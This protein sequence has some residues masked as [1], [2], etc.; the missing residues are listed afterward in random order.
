V[1]KIIAGA[2]A[3]AAVLQHKHIASTVSPTQILQP[4][5]LCLV[6]QEH[7]PL[8]EQEHKVLHRTDSFQYP[9]QQ[10]NQ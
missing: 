1:H 8:P 10:T 6:L 9:L 5:V 4:K 2:A 7:K 3:A